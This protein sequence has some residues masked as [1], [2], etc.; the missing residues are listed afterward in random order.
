[1]ILL[2][3]TQPSDYADFRSYTMILALECQ[4]VKNAVMSSSAANKYMLTGDDY[5]RRL[6]LEYYTQAVRE[7]NHS[8]ANLDYSRESWADPLTLSIAYLYIR[9]VGCLQDCSRSLTLMPEL[10]ALVF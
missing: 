2:P 8:L 6:S 7:V 9:S 10:T 5:F 3:T 4:S 1:M